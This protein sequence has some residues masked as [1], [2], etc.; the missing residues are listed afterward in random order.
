MNEAKYELEQSRLANATRAERLRGQLSSLE[1]ERKPK[2]KPATASLITASILAACLGA[3]TV[4]QAVLLAIAA[5]LNPARGYCILIMLL[6]LSAAIWGVLHARA[7]ATYEGERHLLLGIA[8][9][10]LAGVVL[11]LVSGL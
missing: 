7:A 3:A 10:G 8:G 2:K 4:T 9:A 11:G 5:G 6:L 1:H